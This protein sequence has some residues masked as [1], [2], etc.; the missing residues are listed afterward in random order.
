M[1]PAKT[2]PTRGPAAA[3]ALIGLLALDRAGAIGAGLLLVGALT[4]ELADTMDWSEWMSRGGEALATLVRVVG[5][6]VAGW[7]ALLGVEAGLRVEVVYTVLAVAALALAAA[8]PAPIQ[9]STAS[10]PSATAASA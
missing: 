3:L 5:A 7:G 10:A 8:R 6:M 4:M 9:A 2:R 1:T